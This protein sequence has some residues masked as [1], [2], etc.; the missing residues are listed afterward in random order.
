MCRGQH[1]VERLGRASVRARKLCGLTRADDG[2]AR[3]GELGL[4][5]L[6]VLRVKRPAAV[7]DDAHAESHLGAVHGGGLVRV[8]VRF[9]VRVGF[10]VEVRVEVRDGVVRVR[11]N[12]DADV[13]DQAAY[14]DVGDALGLEQGGEAGVVSLVRVKV[15][16]KVRVW[17]RVRARVRCGAR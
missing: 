11:A 15:K 6:V 5:I 1:L 16:V 3:G 17:V 13:E 8:R 7:L 12:L 10:G 9:G 4:D 2:D 14:E